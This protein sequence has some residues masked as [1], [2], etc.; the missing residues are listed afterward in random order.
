[1]NEGYEITDSAFNVFLEYV[2]GGSIASMLSKYGKFEDGLAKSMT[3]QIL[4][5]L[6]YLHGRSVYSL[7]FLIVRS[8]IHRDIKGANSMSFFL[9]V[10]Y[11]VL[12]DLNGCAKISDFGTSKKHGLLFQ[13]NIYS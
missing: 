12:V 7:L 11:Q 13:Y 9:S 5:G 2:P 1:M 10:S 3:A 6:K 4:L 8:I